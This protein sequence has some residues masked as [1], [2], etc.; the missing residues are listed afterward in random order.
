MVVEK[1]K[2]GVNIISNDFD[3]HPK[4]FLLFEPNSCFETFETVRII[5][6]E[7]TDSNEMFPN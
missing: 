2:T 5:N 3:F 6:Y 1:K 7:C 4:H